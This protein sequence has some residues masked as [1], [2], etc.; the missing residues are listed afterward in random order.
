[1]GVIEC[2]Y[3]A[4]E[5]GAAAEVFLPQLR[6]QSMQVPRTVAGGTTLRTAAT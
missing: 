6:G 4:G 5:R 2:R 3:E 1:M